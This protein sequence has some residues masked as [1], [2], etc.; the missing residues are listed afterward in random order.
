MYGYIYLTTN[1]INNKKYIGQHKSSEFTKNYKGSGRLLWKAI[2]KYGWDNFKVEMIEECNSLEELNER[3]A[4]WTKHYNAVESKEFYNLVEGG[5]QP[6]FS[7]ETRKLHSESMKGNT[8]AL[9]N[10]NA[11]GY[12]FTDKQ[13][14]HLSDAK[15]G[16]PLSNKHRISLSKALIG[17][18]R[19][20]GKKRSEETRMKMSISG[21]GKHNTSGINNPCYGKKKMTNDGI[22]GVFIKESDVNLYINKGYVLWK[23]RSLIK[24][25][26]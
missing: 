25:S 10:S 17:N 3:E 23:D 5:N 2:N 7:E 14:K 4:Y 24:G 13:R 18:T 6:G 16:I 1:L 8:N 22:H 15:K 9:G 20:K 21:K 11:L 19:S 26:V 12:R